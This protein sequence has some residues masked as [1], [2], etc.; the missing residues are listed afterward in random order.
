M[1][2]PSGTRESTQTAVGVR[3]PRTLLRPPPSRRTPSNAPSTVAGT[4]TELRDRRGAPPSLATRGHRQ[5]RS[6]HSPLPRAAPPRAAHAGGPADLSD[7]RG[8]VRAPSPPLLGSLLTPNLPCYSPRTPPPYP[9]THSLRFASPLARHRRKVFPLPRRRRRPRRLVRHA[10]P[11]SSL[12]VRRSLR[13]VRRRPS[14][15]TALP[16]S[17]LGG[18]P[19]RR[20]LRRLHPFRPLPSPRRME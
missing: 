20:S 19:S 13:L 1:I 14:K 18:R 16:L 10:C 17:S 3:G 2:S 4:H 11:L 5:E 9:L 8:V 12:P 7:V 6:E 15:R